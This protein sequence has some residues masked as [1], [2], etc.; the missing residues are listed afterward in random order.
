MKCPSQCWWICAWQVLKSKKSIK[1]AP[2]NDSVDLSGILLALPLNKTHCRANAQQEWSWKARN[3]NILIV[4][5][6]YGYFIYILI[7][8]IAKHFHL[9][10]LCRQTR[11]SFQ[12]P[13]N[14][15]SCKIPIQY[16][17][18]SE[19]LFYTRPEERNHRNTSQLLVSEVHW[20]LEG[21]RKSA[22]NVN[23][24]L[25]HT[26]SAVVERQIEHRTHRNQQCRNLDAGQ[27][28]RL[29]KTTFRSCMKQ[30]YNITNNT[31]NLLINVK[32]LFLL[33]LG[34]W[35]ILKCQSPPK[36]VKLDPNLVREQVGSSLQLV[37]SYQVSGKRWR[38]ERPFT[39]LLQGTQRDSSS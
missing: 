34:S 15:F 13:Y 26:R 32:H 27:A 14:D 24:K 2:W 10:K 23:T 31:G 16:T 7:F 37:W 11:S 18:Q 20:F 28:L 1:S 36:P 3:K 6:R 19:P 4:I 30:Y 9:I 25:C 29:P 22:W 8:I 12:R 5:T 33:H 35:S 21:G 38:N 39:H 17:V